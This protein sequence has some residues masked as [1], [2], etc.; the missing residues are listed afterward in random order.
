[1]MA[2]ATKANCQFGDVLG[3]GGAR[4]EPVHKLRLTNNTDRRLKI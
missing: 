3:A 1:M 2:I 4:G